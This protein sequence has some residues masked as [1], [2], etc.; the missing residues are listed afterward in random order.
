MATSDTTK[1]AAFGPIG[2]IE[3]AARVMQIDVETDAS[4]A[5]TAYF[6]KALGY[7]HSIRYIKDDYDNGV[8]FAITNETNSQGIWSEAA[9]NASA[10]RFPRLLGHTAAGA[11]LSAL[12]AAE[13]AFLANERVKVVI[14]SGGNVKSGSFELVVVPQ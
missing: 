9:V 12:A 11:T 10:T 14:S 2:S 6:P 1:R 13:R 4:G 5:A 8:T 7:V 3:V